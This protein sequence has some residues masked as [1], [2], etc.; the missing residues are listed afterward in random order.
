MVIK[1]RGKL[2]HQ[3]GL[4]MQTNLNDTLFVEFPLLTTGIEN[5]LYFLSLS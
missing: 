2:S 4:D 1:T 3:F 5:I